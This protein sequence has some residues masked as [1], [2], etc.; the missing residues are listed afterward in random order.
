MPFD[1]TTV[2]DMAVMV[3]VT[4]KADGSGFDANIEPDSNV[5]KANI[6]GAIGDFMT[7]KSLD[8]PINMGG[9]SSHSSRGGKS[10]RNKKSKGGKSKKARKSLRRK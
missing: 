9:S 2:D 5:E 7:K 4:P 10:R 6:L 1:Y 3:K 8:P